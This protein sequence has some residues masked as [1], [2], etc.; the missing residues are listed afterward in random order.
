MAPSPTPTTYQPHHTP[1]VTDT[2]KAPLSG[3]WTGEFEA[4]PCFALVSIA[5]PATSSWL[6][7]SQTRRM[8][9]RLAVR[10]RRCRSSGVTT[11][12][13]A[14]SAAPATSARR[15]HDRGPQRSYGGAE[16][17]E[18]RGRDLVLGE[19]VD[20]GADHHRPG[21][22]G[23]RPAGGVPHAGVPDGHP[24]DRATVI[25]RP[26]QLGDHVDPDTPPA[27]LPAE[28]VGEGDDMPVARFGGAGRREQVAAGARRTGR[29]GQGQQRARDLRAVGGS[30][31]TPGRQAPGRA[32]RERP[33]R[34]WPQKRLNSPG[35]QPRRHGRQVAQHGR[36]T[37]SPG[38]NAAAGGPAVRLR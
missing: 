13:R 6:R 24:A 7:S 31:S 32:A 11:P 27:G 19:N 3:L 4:R 26:V 37:G 14:H 28:P 9:T 18:R 1:V 38:R 25:P 2:I 23:D 21:V 34:P 35:T 29:W 15:R 17:P 30:E 12:R 5:F 20:Q 22:V 16:M 8:R 36:P 33:R 10:C